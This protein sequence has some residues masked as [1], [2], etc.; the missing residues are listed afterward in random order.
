[1]LAGSGWVSQ[2]KVMMIPDFLILVTILGV[3]CFAKRKR[4]GIEG[5]HFIYSRVY[6]RDYTPST[7]RVIRSP[8]CTRELTSRHAR[9][10]PWWCVCDKAWGVI[11]LCTPDAVCMGASFVA[12]LLGR[13]NERSNVAVA[14]QDG[15]MCLPC[16]LQSGRGKPCLVDRGLKARWM[17]HVNTP[18]RRCLSAGHVFR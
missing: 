13:S 9:R 1:M 10:A 3:S 16:G 14:V 17:Y 18:V 2:G 4:Y 6:L 15:K 11:W 12:L 8:R 7:A 5:V